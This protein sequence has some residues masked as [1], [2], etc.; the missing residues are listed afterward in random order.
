LQHIRPN[1]LDVAKCKHLPVSIVFLPAADIARYVGEGDVDMGITGLDIIAESQSDVEVL[2]KLDMGRC[3]LAVQAPAGRY[4]DAT[5]LVGKRIVT[6]FPNLARAYFD[7]L[8]RKDLGTDVKYVSG[9][10]EVACALGL[11]DGIV[12]LV[13]TGTT[14]RAA[15]LE[16]IGTVMETET[17]LI[18]NKH[19]EHADMVARLTK[20]IQGYLTAQSNSMLTYNVPRASLTDAIKIT[21]GAKSPTL[22]PLEDDTWVSVTV[23]VKSETVSDVMDRLQAIGAESLLVF[24]VSNCRV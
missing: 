9:S 22:S 4:T 2:M 15:G 10:V 21:P 5:D 18:K 1:R 14:M 24:G 23:M 13:E 11:A 3:K 20:R 7:K 19:A 6:S 8:D 12:D 16:M 17:V